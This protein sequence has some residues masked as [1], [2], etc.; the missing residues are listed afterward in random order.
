M[1]VFA[2]ALAWAQSRPDVVQEAL[3]RHL[4]LS[5]AAMGIAMLLAGPAGW[6]IA[7]HPRAA[8]PVIALFSG[9]RVVPSLAILF[10]AVPVMGIGFAPALLALT[11]L[12]CPPILINTYAAFRGIDTDVLEAARGM[13]MSRTL[14]LGRVEIPL[15]APV[16]VT[17]MRTASVEVIASATLAAFIGAGGLGDFITLGFALDRPAVMLVGALPVAALALIS[18]AGMGALERR[19]RLA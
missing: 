13:G 8:E 12:A 6:W 16:V 1:E 11:A 14:L 15:A 18:E 2:E 4:E 7:S 5:A 17:G 9:V 3:I 10:L 19:L